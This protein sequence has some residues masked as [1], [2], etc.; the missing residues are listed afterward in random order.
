MDLHLER[1]IPSF[2]QLT[3]E[4][5]NNVSKFF[6]ALNPIRV[7]SEYWEIYSKYETAILS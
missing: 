7:N 4:N 2:L 5:T 3:E 6:Y 1:I